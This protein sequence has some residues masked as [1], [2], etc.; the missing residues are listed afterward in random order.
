[1]LVPKGTPD[2]VV[3]KLNGAL[4]TALAD[5]EV[6]SRLEKLDFGV[7]GSTPEAFFKEMKSDSDRFA[8]T[9]RRHPY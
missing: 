8:E 7:E 9:C 6:K 4:N 1:M 5:P 3:R 2:G